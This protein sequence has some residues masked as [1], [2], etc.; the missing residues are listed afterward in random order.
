MINRFFH[1][2]DFIFSLLCRARNVKYF[3]RGEKSP[4]WH[5]SEDFQP[6]RATLLTCQGTKDLASL[7]IYLHKCCLQ[8]LHKVTIFDLMLTSK[9]TTEFTVFALNNTLNE[10]QKYCRQTC[11]WL[12]LSYPCL[13]ASNYMFFGCLYFLSKWFEALEG[14][15]EQENSGCSACTYLAEHITFFGTCL[16]KVR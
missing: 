11:R 4:D 8:K 2:C 5:W 16:L 3:D 10:N 14:C 1:S 15:T 7:H 9:K 6:L 13:R 12:T